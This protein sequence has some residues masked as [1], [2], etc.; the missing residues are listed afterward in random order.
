[1]RLVSV[2]LLAVLSAALVL[3]QSG[4][5]TILGTVSDPTG[6]VMPQVAVTVTNV[7]TNVKA[8]VDTDELGNY[9]APSLIPGPYSVT[10]EK[11]GFKSFKREG[12]VLVLDATVRVDAEMAV[13]AVGQS[14]EVVANASLLETET[15]TS[16]TVVPNVVVVNA[17]VWQRWVNTFAY[18]SPNVKPSTWSGGC[19]RSR[20]MA[21]PCQSGARIA[22]RSMRSYW[23]WERMASS[24]DRS[25]PQSA[26]KVVG[27]G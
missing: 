8:V 27:H 11:A 10:F 17:P 25:S 15:S 23:S 19:S 16:G 5:G 14:V 22:S 2:V 20:A 21:L 4:R 1:M 24:K 6:A 7:E 18:L 3:A 26:V 12:I 13:G 9:R